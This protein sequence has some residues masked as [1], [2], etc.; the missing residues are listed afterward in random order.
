MNA[1]RSM[2]HL[3][4]AP[5]VQDSGSV[6]LGVLDLGSNSFHLL[7]AK[8]EAGAIEPLDKH[9]KMVRLGAGTLRSGRLDAETM[10][11]GLD[12]VAELAARAR[13]KGAKN[14]V[15]VATSALRD[16]ANRAE[17]IERA[18]KQSDIE[19]EI[20]SGEDE[21]RLIYLG[22]SEGARG[23]RAVGDIGGGSGEIIAGHG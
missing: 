3:D 14:V 13:T 19:I 7:V 2:P 6:K 18:R 17:F 5:G 20:L 1:K 16:S 23:R 22:A 21:G 11:R 4:T 12:A 8:V 9:K 10:R 15:A